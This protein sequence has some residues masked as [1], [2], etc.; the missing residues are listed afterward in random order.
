MFELSQLTRKTLMKKTILFLAGIILSCSLMSAQQRGNDVIYG[1][2]GTIIRGTII[3]QSPG[4]SYKIQTA[5]GNIFVF[6][7]DE[8][9]KVDFEP[10]AQPK[11][12]SKGK[13]IKEKNPILAFVCSFAFPGLGQIVNGDTGL[14]IGLMVGNISGL[15]AIYVGYIATLASLG[16]SELSILAPLGLVISAGCG[17]YSMIQA[18]IAATRYNRRYGLALGGG[19]TLNLAPD[20][21]LTNSVARGTNAAYGMRLSLNF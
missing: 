15:F 11:V 5:E 2:N 16:R 7:A 21:V 14:G 18:P 6:K 3:E 12:D 13:A 17:L 4:E 10:D 8:V 9:E 1:K 20:M 19:R